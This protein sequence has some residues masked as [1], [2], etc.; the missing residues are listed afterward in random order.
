VLS[1][2]RTAALNLLRGECALWKD[3]LPLTARA[4]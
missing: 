4:E 2:L 1:L 3:K